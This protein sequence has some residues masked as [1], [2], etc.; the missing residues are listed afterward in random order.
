GEKLGV[1][2]AP[3][4]HEFPECPVRDRLTDPGDLGKGNG[5]VVESEEPGPIFCG[6]KFFSCMAPADRTG[7]GQGSEFV[8][9]ETPMSSEVPPL[10]CIKRVR[11]RVEEIAA[12]R[13]GERK[14]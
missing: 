7:T 1:V 3:V 8:D 12:H 14:H 6:S 9:F 13:C 2:P 5:E 4:V 11:G 10:L